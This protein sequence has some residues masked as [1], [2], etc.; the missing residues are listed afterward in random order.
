MYTW[1]ALNK[2]TGLSKKKKGHKVGS[3]C[4]RGSFGELEG[5]IEGLCDHVSLYTYMEFSRVK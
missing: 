2:L 1:A 5:G 3:G 4:V